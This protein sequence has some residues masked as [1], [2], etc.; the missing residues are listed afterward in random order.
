[1]DLDRNLHKKAIVMQMGTQNLTT[2]YVYDAVK[3]QF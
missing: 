2:K 3:L 1:M